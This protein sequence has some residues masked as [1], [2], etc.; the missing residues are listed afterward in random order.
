MMYK[1]SSDMLEA[2]D[3]DSLISFRFF[4]KNRENF[5][6]MSG[7]LQMKPLHTASEN[8]PN[9]NSSPGTLKL[10]LGC[11]EKELKGS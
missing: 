3:G 1:A 7:V 8:D 11:R 2:G 4:R 9:Q 6:E 5:F 10:K